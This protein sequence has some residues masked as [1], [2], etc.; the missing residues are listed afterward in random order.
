MNLLQLSAKVNHTL[1]RSTKS[2]AITDSQLLTPRLT[3]SFTGHDMLTGALQPHFYSSIWLSLLVL[4]ELISLLP[5]LPMLS[6]YLLVSSLLSQATV[7]LLGDGTSWPVL[8]TSS[9]STSWLLTDDLL[10]RTRTARLL[11]SS[12]QLPPI[13]WFSGLL[14]QSSGL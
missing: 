2:T 6:W 5:W 12:P 8:L 1:S 7:L 3:V 10:S 14:T 9:L 4:T 11:L 13:P